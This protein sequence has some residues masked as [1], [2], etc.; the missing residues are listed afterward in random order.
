M[1]RKKKIKRCDLYAR[2]ITDSVDSE[3]FSFREVLLKDFV[4]MH[5]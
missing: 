4:S 1:V 2:I 5:M 3:Q